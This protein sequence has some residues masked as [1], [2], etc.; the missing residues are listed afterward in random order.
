MMEGPPPLRD[1]D[2]TMSAH[3]QGP[4]SDFRKAGQDEFEMLDFY[5]CLRCFLTMYLEKL[6]S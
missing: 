2:K 4:V 3:G 6:S 1:R 5:N